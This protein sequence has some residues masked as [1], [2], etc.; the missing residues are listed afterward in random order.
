MSAFPSP[1]ALVEELRR[2]RILLPAP[3]VLERLI[4][5]A[6]ARAERVVH[7]ALTARMDVA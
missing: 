4:H 6:R 3:G 1:A 7:R 2:R 5:E